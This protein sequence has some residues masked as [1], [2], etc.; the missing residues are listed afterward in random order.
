MLLN[1][2]EI[3]HKKNILIIGKNLHNNLKWIILLNHLEIKNKKNIL[4]IGKNLHYNLK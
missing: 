4:I 1:H 2:L 3:K